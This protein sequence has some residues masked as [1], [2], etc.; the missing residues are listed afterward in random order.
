MT[1]EKLIITLSVNKIMNKIKIAIAL[2]CLLSTTALATTLSEALINTYQNNPELIA[3]RENLKITDEK[4]SN[5]ISGFLPKIAYTAGKTNSKRDTAPANQY[6][7]QLSKQADWVNT[8]TKHSGIELKQNLFDGGKTV[9]AVQ[10][11]KYTIES[12]RADL[13][14]TEQ[15]LLLDAITAYLEIVS[16][17]QVLDITTENFQAYE[18]RYDAINDKLK[19]GVAKVSDLATAA[20]AR[21]NAYTELTSAS[22]RYSSAIATYIQVI[23][24]EPENIK[25][26]KNLTTP[27]ANQ[28]DLLKF[29][30]TA[31][32]EL[33]SLNF[34]KKASDI[35]LVSSAAEMLP[36]VDLVGGMNKDWTDVRAAPGVSQPYTNSKSVSVNITV[37]IFN[38]GLE[39]SGIRSSSADAAKFKYLLKNTRAKVTQLASQSWNDYLSTQEGIKSAEEAVKAA[40]VALDGKQQEYNEGLGTLTELL[41]AQKNLFDYKIRLTKVRQD[42]ELSKYNMA[43]LMGKL[44]AKDLSLETKI[45]N[46]SAN[47]DKIKFKIIGF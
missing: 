33:S 18:K 5:A 26:E 21:A 17:K 1:T 43:S 42:A 34:K 35:N 7:T 8:K 28:M 45:Y 46:A 41:D 29:S 25:I 12:G 27:P 14:A 36:S 2:S 15:K 16:S 32:P 13:L 39:Y 10:I 9:M 19:V 47:Y 20:A 3:A 22:G 6:T 37:P 38:Q 30:L 40:D 11:A 4:M 44:N 24:I 31:N 23:G